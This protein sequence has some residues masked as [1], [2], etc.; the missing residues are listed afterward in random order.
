M[1]L[2]KIF[3]LGDIGL[4]NYNFSRIINHI[5]L[6]IQKDDIIVYQVHPH[7]RGEYRLEVQT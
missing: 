4:L 3:L 7:T 2:K 6:N 5:S 1:N